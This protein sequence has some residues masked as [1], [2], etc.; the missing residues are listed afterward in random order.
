M[1]SVVYL[2]RL[3]AFA[4]NRCLDKTWEDAIERCDVEMKQSAVAGLSS[5]VCYTPP[6]IMNNVR[7]YYEC[8][9]FTVDYILEN[10]SARALKISWDK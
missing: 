2:K 4:K 3:S 10:G 6:D 1:S 8:T 7:L 5:A 9:G